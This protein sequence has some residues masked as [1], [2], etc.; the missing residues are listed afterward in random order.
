MIVLRV[1]RK[2]FRVLGLIP[3]NSF[4][5]RL[6]NTTLR[7]YHSVVLLAVMIPS[8]LFLVENI[9]DMSKATLSCYCATATAL[10]LSHYWYFIYR[11]Y[12]MA[13]IFDQLQYLVDKSILSNYS[14]FFLDLFLLIAHR[15]SV[16]ETLCQIRE[17]GSGARVVWIQLP[18]LYY[19]CRFPVFV[20]AHIP[21]C[22]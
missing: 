18:S 12:D 7:I 10:G 15:R 16:D 20:D 21:G 4:Y 17:N 5:D 13:A 6:L 3:A 11:C 19:I 2:T 9:G 8:I 14:V 22:H 1:A